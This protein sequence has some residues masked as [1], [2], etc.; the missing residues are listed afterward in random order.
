MNDQNKPY[1]TGGFHQTPPF[2][3][4]PILYLMDK[5]LLLSF[6]FNKFALR[7]FSKYMRY[8][9]KPGIYQAYHLNLEKN[10]YLD[11]YFAIYETNKNNSAVRE[12]VKNLDGNYE[13]K[14]VRWATHYEQMQNTRRNHYVIY[15][16]KK[17]TVSAAARA[18]GLKRKQ[19]AT[20]YKRLYRGISIE[21]AVII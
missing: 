16:G 3:E 18:A 17:L 8:N 9:L 5:I 10:K 21:K 13:P 4:F 11:K 19:F 2:K 20:V 12:V 15:Q 1:E 14:N 7:F 6:Q